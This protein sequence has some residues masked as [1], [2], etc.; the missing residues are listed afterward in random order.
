MRPR[1][2]DQTLGVRLRTYLRRLGQAW[3]TSPCWLGSTVPVTQGV[4]HRV[5]KHLLMAR[6]LGGRA[7]GLEGEPMG[8]AGSVSDPLPLPEQG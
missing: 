6:G 3:R 2:L 7:D 1:W 4:P 5:W 8:L